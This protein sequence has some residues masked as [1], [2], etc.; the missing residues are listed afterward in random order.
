[1]SKT[2]AQR[3]GFDRNQKQ[4]A[5]YPET[6]DDLVS[7]RLLMEQ[8]RS[9]READKHQDVLA[10]QHIEMAQVCL[11][12]AEIAPL[13]EQRW[14]YINRANALL[15][16]ACK[17]VA[18]QSACLL[19]LQNLF[20]LLKGF[21]ERLPEPF[22]S[23]APAQ[24]EVKTLNPKRVYEVL[25]TAAQGWHLVNEQNAFST[26]FW[27]KAFAI[28][29]WLLIIAVVGT[30][31]MTL[32]C[33]ADKDAQCFPLPFRQLDYF[34]AAIF[35]TLGGALSSLLGSRS[36][37]VSA[38]TFRVSRSQAKMRI[39]LGA[40]GAFIV[41]LAVKSDLVFRSDISEAVM[42]FPVLALVSISA[43]F[44]ERMFL[45]ALERIAGTVEQARDAD[46][47]KGNGGAAAFVPVDHAAQLAATD[48]DDQ[49]LQA[50]EQADAAARAADKAQA[51]VED[52]LSKAEEADQHAQIDHMDQQLQSGARPKGKGKVG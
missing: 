17:S 3:L 27:Q 21:K 47:G 48:Q 24:I 32:P 30:E 34:W 29:L 43:G 52:E 2:M 19:R 46:A 49:K 6:S 26:K 15:A 8:L 14:S 16:F 35:G 4:K 25:E 7:V 36:V 39:L 33:L 42:R 12:E 38:T 50:G 9:A 51:D 5:K 22:S 11:D 45:S 10:L 1:M 28:Q 44:S 37:F 20:P 18:E 23:F 13:L 31:I 41:V 40:V